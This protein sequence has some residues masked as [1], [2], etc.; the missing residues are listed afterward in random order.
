M[1]FFTIGHSNRTLEGFIGL[2][3][4]H[5]ITA[6]ADVRSSPYSRMWPHFD[7]GPL[8]QSL[9]KHSIWYVHLGSELG[10]RPTA[11]S[12]Y[13]D[14]V[15]DYEAMARQ[16]QFEQGIGRLVRGV[17]T[18]R[19]C[20]MCSEKLP[21]I[22]HR[23]LLVGRALRE[24]GDDVV[25]IIDETTTLSQI[26]VEDKLLK[27]AALEPLP[28][29]EG[30]AHSAKYPRNQLLTAAYMAQARRAAFRQN[31]ITENQDVA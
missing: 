26:Q 13:Q 30:N 23:C 18:Y 19:I 15:A 6:L 4:Q 29:F 10:G 11:A 9:E 17:R 2:L 16:S 8:K 28:I 22:C 5:D 25:H 21:E 31:Q 20:L 1:K 3:K 14:G 12:L 24:R 27:L 7:Q